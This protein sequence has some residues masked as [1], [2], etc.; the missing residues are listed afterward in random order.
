MACTIDSLVHEAV[1]SLEEG[2]SVQQAA[3]LMA[4]FDVH[5][6]AALW[7]K[8]DELIARV[9][10]ARAGVDVEHRPAH[11]LT[12]SCTFWSRDFAVSPQVLIPRPET[13]RL[14]EKVCDLLAPPG[15]RIVDGM[16]AKS[17]ASGSGPISETS[18]QSPSRIP[19]L[20]LNSK[21]SGSPRCNG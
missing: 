21:Q 10:D 7:S 3:E 16:M 20:P 6:D 9:A 17:P 15:S 11:H 1:A 12:G 2:A 5:W 4:E 13:E 8:R 14:V 19:R 18:F